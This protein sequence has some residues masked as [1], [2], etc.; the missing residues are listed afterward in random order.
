MS[1]LSWLKPATLAA[2]VVV[3]GT[4]LAAAPVQAQDITVL[5]G[6]P[7]SRPAASVDCNNPYYSQ[8][9]QAYDAWYNQNYGQNQYYSTYDYGDA[10]PYYGY[11]LPVGVGLGFGFFHHDHD[12]RFHGGGFHAG[13]FHGG[14]HGG[15]FHGG[16]VHGGGGFHGGGGRR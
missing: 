9:C 1:S 5:R 6:S 11:G 8:Y 12:G 4:L 3:A 14:F 2:T 7:P 13:N 15:G 16:G 10:Y